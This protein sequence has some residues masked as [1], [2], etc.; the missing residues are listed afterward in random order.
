MS[1]AGIGSETGVY[2]HLEH[3]SPLRSRR[4]LPVFTSEFVEVIVFR[5]KGRQ[6][7]FLLLKRSTNEKPYPGIWQ[8]VSGRRRRSERPVSTA[9]REVREETGAAPVGLWVLPFVNTFY[10]PAGD[11][12]HVVPTFAAEVRSA[13]KIRLSGEHDDYAWVSR[14]VAGSRVQWP[15]H[16]TMMD[17]V[18]TYVLK[19][20]S[21][22]HRIAVP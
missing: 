21:A 11:A 4:S 5:R 2:W 8:V 3:C 12:V 15:A 16:L 19:P 6:L 14:R 18:R 9:I 7:S 22:V 13:A 20:K 1:E 17:L 10:A